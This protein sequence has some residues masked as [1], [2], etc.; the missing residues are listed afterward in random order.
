MNLTSGTELSHYRIVHKI[1]SGGMGTVYLADDLTLYRKVAIK[2]LK[3]S[4]GAE[5]EAEK[6]LLD[7]A[8]ATAKQEHPARVTVYEVGRFRDLPYVVLEY[9]D[10][11]PFDKLMADGPL[12]PA[13]AVAYV[14]QLCEGLREAHAHGTVHGDIKPSNLM[15][16]RHGRVRILDFGMARGIGQPLTA[17]GGSPGGTLRY[18]APEILMELPAEPRSDLFS[19]GVLLYHM[20]SG[21]LPFSGPYDAAV[22]Y[23][24]LN[25]TPTPLA[26]QVPGL[27]ADLI[28]VVERLL[29]KN[30][31]KRYTNAGDL[32]DALSALGQAD[33]KGPPPEVRAPS[34]RWV[35]PATG[36]AVLFGLLY[37][38][39][40]LVRPIDPS[41]PQRLSL[42]VLP[43]ENLGAQ[44]DEY[45]A[46]GMTDEVT[47]QLA[48]LPNVT[49]ISRNSAMQ[50]KESHERLP[51]IAAELGADYL[52]TGS[53]HWER[54][55]TDSVRV[56][57][58]LVRPSDDSYVWTESFEGDRNKIFQFQ[59]NLPAQVA[60]ALHK[61]EPMP[62][63]QLRPTPNLE[64]YD[65][66]LRGNEF[67]SRTWD[68]REL[69]SAGSLYAKA[70]A[71]DSNFAAAWAKLSRVDAS[72]FSERY[73]IDPGRCEE[74]FACA[75][76]ALNLD[77]QLDLGYL[78][79]G[80]C[81]YQCQR[82]NEA[83][84]QEFQRGLQLNPNQSDLHNAVAA[85]QR[86][87]G[88]CAEA[89]AGFEEALRLDPLAHLTALDVSLTLGMLHRYDEAVAYADQTILLAPDYALAQVYRAWLPVLG[90]GDTAE[91]RR[92]LLK[93]SR[94]TDLTTSSYYWWLMRILE[95]DGSGGRSMLSE[96]SDIM[97]YELYRARTARAFGRQAEDRAYSDSARQWIDRHLAEQP[98]NVY[99]M[100]SL[101]VALVGLQQPDSAI[102]LANKAVD[103]SATLSEPF[104]EPF[105]YLNL[106]E[107]L[108]T[109]GQ[110]DPALH[111]LELIMS[112]PGFASPDYLKLDPLWTPLRGLPRFQAL[113]SPARDSSAAVIP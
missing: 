113:L 64:A 105:L 28:A 92:I 82:D 77:P 107:I 100:S 52:V 99:F 38:G 1:G 18:M 91:A 55:T 7:E 29:E 46:D 26:T 11:T 21:R 75:R 76:R 67:F 96:H 39:W 49:V 51:N 5:G 104:E 6:N 89:L 103:L 70:V 16:D 112:N 84:I 15:L 88:Q 72:M 58:S 19:V 10:G 45:Y 83:A 48:R 41:P 102:R 2:F 54:E 65:L 47:M 111:V 90:H 110:T 4:S 12:E 43:F 23:A 79:L 36:A 44:G 74:A 81:Y 62:A 17:G 93:A 87:Q 60:R 14:G 95:P 80:Y 27:P 35:R 24:I 66:Y 32:K 50:Y 98:E 106:A 3:A 94:K 68:K 37:S 13:Q 31:D 33:P 59:E 9:V 8:R 40:F 63:S 109:F 30:P 42:A 53:I 56:H 86:R 69:E 108:A 101:A 97:S 73:D 78:A 34:R 22:S 61:S 20:L 57:V 71:L 85:V 25:E